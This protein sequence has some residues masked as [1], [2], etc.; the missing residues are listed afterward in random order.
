M[1][2]SIVADRTTHGIILIYKYVVIFGIPQ[3]CLNILLF[4]N[5]SVM[6]VSVSGIKSVEFRTNDRSF[7]RGLVLFVRRVVAR[8]SLF[9]SLQE[10]VIERLDVAL[11]HHL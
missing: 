11:S 10:E 7:R 9:C 1:V 4:F 6:I 3:I 2:I 5:W 8:V